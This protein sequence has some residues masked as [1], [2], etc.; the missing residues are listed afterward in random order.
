MKRILPVS[1]NSFFTRGKTVL[2]EMR[3]MRAGERGVFDDRDRGVGPAERPFAERP[4]GHQ[5]GGGRHVERLV[6]GGIGGG[7]PA[8]AAAKRHPDGYEQQ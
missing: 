2:L 8:A 5:L 4:L 6:G 1:I 7:D 3:A